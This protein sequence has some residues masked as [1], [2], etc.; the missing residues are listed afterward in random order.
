MKNKWLVFIFGGKSFIGTIAGK[1]LLVEKTPNKAIDSAYLGN[2]SC[3]CKM[4]FSFCQRSRVSGP[5]A[6]RS[7]QSPLFFSRRFSAWDCHSNCHRWRLI[8]FKNK[9]LEKLHLILHKTSV[10]QHGKLAQFDYVISVFLTIDS[11]VLSKL[12]LQIKHCLRTYLKHWSSLTL[13]EY[14]KPLKCKLSDRSS[15]SELL[16]HMDFLQNTIFLLKN[17][18]RG[19]R[20]KTNQHSRFLL[21]NTARG[22]RIKTNQHS[23]NTPSLCFSWN[24]FMLLWSVFWRQSAWQGNYCIHSGESSEDCRYFSSNPQLANDGYFQGRP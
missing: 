21:K 5:G 14:L 13:A 4:V 18:A 6:L 23:G 15:L 20:I 17:T 12:H 10:L 19:F 9:D 24:W 1:K 22:F 16:S 8:Q 7:S 2:Y 3:R 11:P